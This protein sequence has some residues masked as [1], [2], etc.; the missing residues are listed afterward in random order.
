MLGQIGKDELVLDLGA[1]LGGKLV[2][3]EAPEARV[4][5]DT[6]AAG[7]RR[8]TDT[9]EGYTFAVSCLERGFKFASVFVEDPRINPAAFE[10]NKPIAFE[11]LTGE[12]GGGYKDKPLRLY[13]SATAAKQA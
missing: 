10:P 8:P 9:V 6:D 3:A 7:N 2:L 13:L 11:G 4:K 1:T 12:L 5:W